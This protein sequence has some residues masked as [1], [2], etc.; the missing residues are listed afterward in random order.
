LVEVDLRETLLKFVAPFLDDTVEVFQL[1]KGEVPQ[2]GVVDVDVA[3]DLKRLNPGLF[4]LSV[5]II[6]EAVLDERKT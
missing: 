5:E 6:P 4:D 2:F 3:E 1:G